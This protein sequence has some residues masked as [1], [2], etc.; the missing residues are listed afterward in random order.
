MTVVLSTCCASEDT[1][2]YEELGIC[3]DCGEH[4]EWESA[5]G[6]EG[7]T[8]DAI[9]EVLADTY[10]INTEDVDQVDM[11]DDLEELFNLDEN[12]YDY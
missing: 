6:E 8:T 3:P 12:P 7:L 4:C 9:E 5:A 1:G 11:L 10:A 2:N